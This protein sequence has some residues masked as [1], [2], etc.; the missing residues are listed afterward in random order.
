MALRVG[1]ALPTVELVDHDGRPW[2]TR[3]HLG[4]PLVLVLHR[5]LA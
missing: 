4:R 5:H 3:D 2:R 1:D